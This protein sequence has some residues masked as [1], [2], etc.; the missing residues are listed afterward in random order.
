MYDV[1]EA[2]DVRDL[3][4]RLALFRRRVGCGNGSG[5]VDDGEGVEEEDG[6]MT[7]SSGVDET[8]FSNESSSWG[9]MCPY[10]WKALVELGVVVSTPSD[11]LGEDAVRTMV[12]NDCLFDNKE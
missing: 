5:S 2:E 8:L 4:G 10:T 12:V 6:L 7:Y 3:A 9:V 11:D 1:D